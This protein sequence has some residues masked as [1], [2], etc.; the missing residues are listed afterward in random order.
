MKTDIHE[1]STVLNIVRESQLDG[2]PTPN[3]DY[4]EQLP[5]IHNQL[6]QRNESVT[7]MLSSYV[8]ERCERAK[9][10]M[11]LKMAVFVFFVVLLF[12]L[13]VA[14]VLFL[15]RMS[16]KDTVS[17][18]V[19]VVSALV[20]YFASVI[21]IFEIITKYLFPLDEEKNTINMMKTILDND[22]KVEERVSAAI[23]RNQNDDVA[24][25]KA[26]KQLLD[27][28]VLTS[29]EFNKLKNNIITPRI[30]K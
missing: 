30:E 13:T 3:D 23:E 10:N 2:E 14:V 25:L 4:A 12:Y 5:R 21:G 27:D 16:N 1:I 18:A 7:K 11:R 8:D 6:V 17:S 26:L 9:V 24:R 19:S 15:A 22:V 29:E 20:T 28:E